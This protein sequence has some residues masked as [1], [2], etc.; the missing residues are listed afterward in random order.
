[1]ILRFGFKNF[2]SMRK[3]QE[4][5]FIPSA[6]TDGTRGLINC[7]AAGGSLLPAAVIYGANASG[8]SNVVRA[9]NFLRS[10][11]LLSHSRGDQETQIPREPFALDEKSANSPTQVDV[12]FVL[13]GGRQPPG[14]PHTTVGRLT[15][16]I[17]LAALQAQ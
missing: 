12:D 2:L 9:L 17:R 13:N 5:S 11:I 10:A 14:P 16:F 8:K 6:L 15:L 1:M 3:A 7:A 4:I